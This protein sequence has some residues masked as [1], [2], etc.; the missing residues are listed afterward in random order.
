[1]S[2]L[3]AARADNYYYGP[4]YGPQHG[5]LNKYR[6]SHGALGDRAKRLHEGILIIRFE[7]PF[8]CICTKCGSYIAKGVRFN[9]EKKCIGN[10]Y[11]TKIW[12][13]RMTCY[14]CDNTFAI[15]TDPEQCEYVILEGLHKKVE[16]W[17]AKDADLPE[18]PSQEEQAAIR[19]DPMLR[20]EKT[21]DDKSKAEAK[22]SALEALIDLQDDRED[23]YAL[24]S[25][26]RRTFRSEKEEIE[27]Q[28]EED[29]KPKNFAMPLLD[30]SHEDRVEASAV[31]FKGASATVRQH[32]RRKNIETQSIF[33]GSG[34]GAGGKKRSAPAAALADAVAKKARNGNG[35]LRSDGPR[36][37]IEGLLAKQKPSRAPLLS[38]LAKR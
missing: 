20:L 30:E 8:K 24:N 28:K 27:R 16:T 31:R 36:S 38:K 13:F 18:L 33:D 32:H 4:S 23:H 12:E 35:F 21:A 1:M 15:K 5:S 26:L 17:D 25:A 14:Y 22:K 11:T 3:A 19:A 7:L 37:R 9:A 29:S 10:Y 2:S 34:N 6:G